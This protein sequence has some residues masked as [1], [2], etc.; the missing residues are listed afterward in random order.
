MPINPQIVVPQVQG[1]Q[2]ENPLSFARNALAMQEAQSTVAANQLKIQ[3]ANALKNVLAAQPGVSRSP[4]E[5][6]NQLLSMGF[7]EEAKMVLDAESA[8]VGAETKRYEA[9]IKGAEILGREAFAFTRD[10]NLLNKQEIRSWGQ[11][12]VQRG[13]MTPEALQRF[14][15]LPEDPQIL[16]A[17]MMRLARQGLGISEQKAEFKDIGGQ[18]IGYDPLA[19]SE[20]GT[21]IDQA[22]LPPEVEAQEARLRAAGRSITTFDMSKKFRDTLG[23]KAALRLDAYRENAEQAARGIETN[24]RL[25]PLLNDPKFISGTFAEAR[26]AVAKAAGI[27]VSATEAFLSGMAEQVAARIK[28]FGAGTGL[29]NADRDYALAWAGGKPDLSTKGIARIMRINDESGDAVIGKYND[30]RNFLA[31]KEPAIIDYYPEVG[32]RG[33]AVGTIKPDTKTG[34]NY[35]FKGGD[36]ANPKNWEKVGK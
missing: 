17:A 12:A 23:E 6:S 8:R 7:P 1:I 9:R 30:E 18:F 19:A 3:R 22:L 14:D 34:E 27:D 29:S 33:V 16:S 28:A 25:R 26:T 2:L 13:L 31:K 10:P 11:T 24:A 35:R 4:E 21:R 32:A 15:Q 20:V 36:P 5:I